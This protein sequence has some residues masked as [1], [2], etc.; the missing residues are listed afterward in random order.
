MRR[1]FHKIQIANR[2][3]LAASE[4]NGIRGLAVTGAFGIIAGKRV[5]I[6]LAFLGHQDHFEREGLVREKTGGVAVGAGVSSVNRWAE[7]GRGGAK[8]RKEGE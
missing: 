3:V 7:I 8:E 6:D 1:V 4:K 2:T 5:A